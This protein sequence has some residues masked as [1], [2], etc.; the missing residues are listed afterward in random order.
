MP[1]SLST[2]AL[3]CATRPVRDGGQKG[4]IAVELALMLPL[5]L[6][7]VLTIVELGTLLN[8]Y[9]ILQNAAREGARISSLPKNNIDSSNPDASPTTIQ[10]AVV[11]YCTD[12]GLAV[13]AGDVS[14]DQ[15]QFVTV[16]A[17]QMGVSVVTV[18]YSV[19][20]ITPGGTTLAGG[21]VTVTGVGVFRNLY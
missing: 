11:D 21:P 17:R 20:L 9:Q 12:R 8:T 19:D 10:D 15:E 5:F 18:S 4:A 2:R 16:G 3:P 7:I 1:Q 13:T 14:V 6:V